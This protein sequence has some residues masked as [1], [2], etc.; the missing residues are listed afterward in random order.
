MC[1]KLLQPGQKVSPQSARQVRVSPRSQ[2]PGH[3]ASQGDGFIGG[4]SPVTAA[5]SPISHQRV[6]PRNLCKAALSLQRPAMLQAEPEPRVQKLR[7]GGT[8][9]LVDVSAGQGASRAAGGP[10]LRRG[11]LPVQSQPSGKDEP[12]QRPALL[13]GDQALSGLVFAEAQQAK[14]PQVHGVTSS[15]LPSRES[16]ARKRLLLETSKQPLTASEPTQTPGEGEVFGLPPSLL[17]S[18]LR[19]LMPSGEQRPQGTSSLR[20]VECI[21]GIEPT[22]EQ[23]RGQPPLTQFPVLL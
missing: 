8:L 20:G 15:P 10:E 6:Q 11:L 2:D 21:G 1:M 18:E 19:S 16:L 14:S 5:A 13:P 17:A 9:R 3:E 23:G 12:E 7:Q 22:R 4:R